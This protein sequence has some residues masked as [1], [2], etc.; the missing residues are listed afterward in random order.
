M[1]MDAR[2]TY[3]DSE[4]ATDATADEFW[5]AA[6]G[7]GSLP[8]LGDCLLNSP[9]CRISEFDTGGTLRE[10]VEVSEGVYRNTISC[11]VPWILNLERI[12]YIQENVETI[13]AELDLEGKSDY[14]KVRT[15][16][17]YICDRVK[18][19]SNGT[20]EPYTAYGALK[21]NQAV[22]QGYALLTYALLTEAGIDCRYI[23]GDV[24]KPVGHAW[25]IVK[26]DGLYYNLDTTWCDENYPGYL[27]EE[28]FLRGATDF[29]GHYRDGSYAS[30]AFQA[31]YPMA[32][33]KYDGT[34]GTVH[35]CNGNHN[36][37]V[38]SPD[39]IRAYPTTT[40]PGEVIYTCSYCFDIKR[41]EL[42][43]LN[44]KDYKY[45][46]ITEP[47]C[48]E[49]GKGEYS[50]EYWEIWESGEGYAIGFDITDTIPAKGHSFSEP[51][52]YPSTPT[53]Q[54]YA[55]RICTECGYCDTYNYTSSVGG[56]VISYLD[57]D[58][59]IELLQDG[60]VVH[61]TVVSDNS[62]TFEAVAAGNY[63][64]RVSKAN[65]ASRTYEITVDQSHTTQD[66]EICPIGDVTGDGLVNI[67]DF[68][69]LL[70]HMNKTN[71]LEGYAL[72]CGDVTDD[73]VCNIKDFQRLLRHV[74]KTNPLF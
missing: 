22:C 42:P 65:H 55:Q 57:G 51:V 28:W 73:G 21:N 6:I 23:S 43:V 29:C 72:A 52:F 27:D 1:Q 74:N 64:L 7:H 68:Q 40:T 19:K 59:T 44:K 20:K 17:Q 14:K 9:D 56:N 34:P 10:S 62:Y 58:V 5:D 53:Q 47:T 41:E 38:T 12:D 4:P 13:I 54:G 46:V 31:K 70:R 15:I 30:E 3:Y 67:K 18:Y 2:V 71:L 60:Q 32:A 49:N 48:T 24:V 25:N 61:S 69:Q 11:C 16:V 39:D 8:S 35:N 63:S 45:K 36:Y 26:I 33:T 50:W 37:G 66:V